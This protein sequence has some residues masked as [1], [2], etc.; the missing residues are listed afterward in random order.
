MLKISNDKSFKVPYAIEELFSDM[1]GAI[2]PDSG[3]IVCFKKETKIKILEDE[4][5]NIIPL[6]SYDDCIAL[7][8]GTQNVV[9]LISCSKA[10]AVD[11]IEIT[12]GHV[13]VKTRDLEVSLKLEQIANSIRLLKSTGYNRVRLYIGRIAIDNKEHE[14]PIIIGIS[15]RGTET[16]AIIVLPCREEKLI[17]SIT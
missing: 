5:G 6:V 12:V 17:E 9:N 3:H 16:I 7:T 1:H 8:M 11:K 4:N 2:D 14:V 13:N 15:D 10:R